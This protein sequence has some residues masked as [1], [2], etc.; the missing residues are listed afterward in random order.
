MLHCKWWRFQEP[1][2]FDGS[3]FNPC[4]LAGSISRCALFCLLNE[5][6][7]GTWT[8]LQLDETPIGTWRFLQLPETTIDYI[9]RNNHTISFQIISTKLKCSMK[10]D[11]NSKYSGNSWCLINVGMQQLKSIPK[12]RTL[13]TCY[14]NFAVVFSSQTLKLVARV[15]VDCG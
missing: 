5:T 6:T 4:K 15:A 3:P 1:I 9:P 13:S 11:A 12:K 8:F 7:V 14:L 10:C 2:L